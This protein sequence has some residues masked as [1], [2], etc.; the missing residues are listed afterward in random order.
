MTRLPHIE[1]GVAGDGGNDDDDDDDGVGGGGGRRTNR[2][3]VCKTIGWITIKLFSPTD[4]QF[5]NGTY[6][7]AVI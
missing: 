2:H 4:C 7:G 1:C 6:T 3:I 5:Y